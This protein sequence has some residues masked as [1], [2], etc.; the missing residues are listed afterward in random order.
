MP[1]LL[2]AALEKSQEQS[3]T[4]LVSVS[5]CVLFPRE[6]T[7]EKLKANGNLETLKAIVKALKGRESAK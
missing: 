7:E 6:C 4:L 2:V 5:A 3:A 1:P